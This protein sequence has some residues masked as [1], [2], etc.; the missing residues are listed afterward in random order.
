MLISHETPIS[1]YSEVSQ[2]FDYD[3]CL[4]HLLDDP[5]F[6]YAYSSKYRSI[7]KNAL[8]NNREVFLDNSIFELGEA[9]DSKKFV[10]HIQDLKPTVYI[11]P[12][13]LDNAEATMD[14]FSIFTKTYSDLPGMK[15]GVVQGK[16]IDE[17]FE[18]YKF[19]SEFADYIAIS[20]DSAV[21]DHIAMG[22]NKLQKLRRGRPQLVQMLMSYGLWNYDKPHHAL[23]MG[24]LTEFKYYSSKRVFR[25][26]DTSNPIMAAIKGQT[27]L[28]GIGTVPYSKASDKLADYMFMDPTEVIL[29]EGYSLTQKMISNVRTFSNTLWKFDH[30]K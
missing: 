5:A 7:F 21:Y 13:V 14:S 29:K 30:M 10:N 18:C 9:Y 26:I 16:N 25:S 1:F 15:M 2:H 19:M 23:G 3:Y 22:H 24:H 12:D 11:I 27:Y 20:F 8:R 4:V 17:V 28:D 6:D